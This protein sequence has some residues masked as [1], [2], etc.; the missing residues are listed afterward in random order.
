MHSYWASF[1]E[2]KAAASSV[3]SMV[4]A[5]FADRGDAVGDRVVAESGGLRED[6]HVEVAGIIGRPAL[7]GWIGLLQAGGDE[8]DGGARRE[9]G[10]TESM[11]C[12][13]DVGLYGR[14]PRRWRNASCGLC[15]H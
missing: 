15:V 6:E 7:V 1:S 9:A 13:H 3:E 8:R 4:L 14:N 5:E 11:A 10:E 12:E 2:V